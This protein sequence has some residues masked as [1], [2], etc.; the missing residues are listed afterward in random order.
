MGLSR[1]IY[2]TTTNFHFG[3]LEETKTK[4]SMDHVDQMN[5]DEGYCS[6]PKKSSEDVSISNITSK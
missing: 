1:L 3:L 6:Y 4:E 5:I 2:T